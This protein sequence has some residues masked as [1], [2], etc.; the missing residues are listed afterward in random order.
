MCGI[1]GIY[2]P[3][4]WLNK[5]ETTKKSAST[6]RHRGPDAEGFFSDDH[7]SLG[8]VRLSI[9]DTS[10]GA[11]QPMFDRSGEYVIV[12]N[13]EIFNYLELKQQ[14]FSDDHPWRTTSDT[15]VLL[16]LYIQQGPKCL[17]LLR[18]FFAL[19][20]YSKKDSS[21]FLA[22]DRFGKKPLYYHNNPDG[23]LAFASELDALLAYQIPR[24]L[25]KVSVKQYL[26]F[27]YIPEPDTI[28]ADVRRL[29]AG[30]YLQIGPKGHKLTRYYDIPRKPIDRSI[31]YDQACQRL[32]DLL[33]ESV[34]DRM[35]ADVPLGSFLSGGIDSSV[36]VSLATRYTD[37]LNTFSI[38]YTD[39]PFFDETH[40]AELVAK[41]L[42]TRHHVFRLSNDDLHAE[43]DN[44]LDSISEPFADSS[45]IPLYILAKKTKQQ[46]TVALSGDGGD[47]LFAGYNKH[48][49]EYALRRANAFR[50][51][52]RLM[53]PI[54]R[55]L[56]ASR[57]SP[58]A[59]KVRQ[60]R[61]FLE[62]MLLSP[63]ERYWNWAGFLS[64]EEA[65]SFLLPGGEDRATY[66]NR[67]K[68][69]LKG[70]REVDSMR[71]FLLTDIGLVL[72]GDML[73]K[74]DRMSMA[75]G[76]EVRSPF[77]DHRVV[78]FALS[79]PDTFK[80]K[81]R[82][83]KRIVQDAFRDRLPS[84]IYDRPK[85]GFEVPLLDWFRGSLRSRIENIYLSDRF[86]QEQ[87]LFSPESVK[88]LKQRLF[89]SNPGD[90]VATTWALIVFQHWWKRY[91]IKS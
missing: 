60:V 68:A 69:I 41:K 9:L 36:V 8:H 71:D 31:S 5:S 13:G 52:A 45:A 29:P 19:A 4:K 58:A 40:Y 48:K 10:G 25:D 87:G 32:I 50:P 73:V 77:L 39:N 33:D 26:H 16:E 62:G 80:I 28:L 53:L 21:L 70:Y 35:V 18:G 27:N 49:A 51:L 83:G 30:N 90:S 11:V 61:K 15:E 85:K 37:K 14:Y 54:T 74:V 7:I 81:G 1:T 82:M 2:Y 75:N 67:K 59:N 86:I 91:A 3:N 76:L 12:F 38:G 55:V 47:E 89:S 22:R 66:E 78:E 56:P 84:E 57:N 46:V 17:D 65:A 20:I 42:D 24:E 23:T 79:L 72:Q 34:R 63:Q 64:D 6:I 88:V 43:L 44:V